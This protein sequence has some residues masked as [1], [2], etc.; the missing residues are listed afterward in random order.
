MPRPTAAA[1]VEPAAG[2]QMRL[3]ALAARW[4][5]RLRTGRRQEA[6]AGVARRVAESGFRLSDEEVCGRG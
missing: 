1:L 2:E 3:A 6:E 4:L 5:M